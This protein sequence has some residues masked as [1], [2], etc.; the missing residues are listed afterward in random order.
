MEA[1][2]RERSGG[3]E[4]PGIHSKPKPVYTVYP[5]ARAL[6]LAWSS[7]AFESACLLSFGSLTFCVLR[8]LLGY[9]IFLMLA[10]PATPSLPTGDVRLSSLQT[11][12]LGFALSV[13]RHTGIGPTDKA[14]GSDGSARE[15]GT[16]AT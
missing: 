6:L 16:N 11:W 2:G 12:S 7:W 10:P 8:F 1:G 14:K 15:V 13:H 5:K 9:R 3:R 4:G